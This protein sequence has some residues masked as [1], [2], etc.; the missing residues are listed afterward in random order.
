[1]SEK[2]RDLD[3]PESHLQNSIAQAA[4][5]GAFSLAVASINETAQINNQ[6]Y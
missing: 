1:M 2:T 5:M 3:S 6:R 4:N